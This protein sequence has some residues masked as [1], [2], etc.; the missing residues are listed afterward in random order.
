MDRAESFSGL[1]KI[2]AGVTIDGQTSRR[3]HLHQILVD[4]GE[5][6]INMHHR[7]LGVGVS[8]GCVE[9]LTIFAEVKFVGEAPLLHL[10]QVR[11][12]D[13]EYLD[14]IFGN[15][16]VDGGGEDPVY[17]ARAD[18]GPNLFAPGKR[19]IMMDKLFLAG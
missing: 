15:A 1:A 19:V 14:V 6:F 12:L 17:V 9:G 18:D 4:L 10:G 11:C 7:R 5:S 8:F 13:N 16:F 3:H 2:V